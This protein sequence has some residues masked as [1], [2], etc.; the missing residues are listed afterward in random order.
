MATATT[1]H[2]SAVALAPAEVW[3]EFL[4]SHVRLTELRVGYCCHGSG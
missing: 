2:S 1:I 3:S 4:A